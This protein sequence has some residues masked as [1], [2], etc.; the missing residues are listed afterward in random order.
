MENRMSL[1][2]I[3]ARLGDGLVLLNVRYFDELFVEQL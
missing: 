1:V 3:V 2:R